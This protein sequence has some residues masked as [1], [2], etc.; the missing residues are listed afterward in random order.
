MP[1]G[2]SVKDKFREQA[3]LAKVVLDHKRSLAALRENHVGLDLRPFDPTNP[4]LGHE[5]IVLFDGM[6]SW[7][8]VKSTWDRVTAEIALILNAWPALYA[9]DVQGALEVYADQ[10]YDATDPLKGG[11]EVWP[12]R[13]Q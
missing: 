7:Q 5:D 9:A 11:E 13:T 4:T 2:P 3:R 6:T 1:N 12:V 10:K 8:W